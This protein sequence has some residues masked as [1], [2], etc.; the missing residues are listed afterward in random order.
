MLF[1]EFSLFSGQFCL[2]PE[3]QNHGHDLGDNDQ[4][5]TPQETPDEKISRKTPTVR[6]S[7]SRN[8][9]YCQ[10]DKEQYDFDK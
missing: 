8:G 1:G 5:A 6:D 4:C 2:F 7:Q 10:G 3:F 9:R